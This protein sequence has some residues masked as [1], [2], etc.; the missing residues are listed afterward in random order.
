MANSELIEIDPAHCPLVNF[1]GE[2]A[3]TGIAPLAPTAVSVTL[4]VKVRTNVLFAACALMMILKVT[5]PT[6]GEVMVEKVK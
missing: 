1:S 6:F 4:P 2:S 3:S 5:Y